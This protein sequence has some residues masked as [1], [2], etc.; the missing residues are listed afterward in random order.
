MLLDLGLDE[1]ALLSAMK[2]KSRYNLRIAQKKGVEVYPCGADELSILYR[3]YAETSTRDGFVIRPENYYV[4]LWGE[5]MAKNMAQPFIAK[6]D[7]EAVAG[8]VL[9]YFGGRAWYLHGMSRPVHREKMP[10]YLL[11]WEA[12]RFAKAKGCKIYDMWGAPDHF[13]EADSMWK[14]YRFKEGL[15]AAASLTIGAWDYAPNPLIYSLYTNIMPRVL[16][17]MRGRGKKRVQNDLN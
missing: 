15:G 8:L 6:V 2:Q 14:V 7:G 4:K 16:N 10:N 3:M 9:F 13:D 1:D 17:I 12:I 11:H 5:F